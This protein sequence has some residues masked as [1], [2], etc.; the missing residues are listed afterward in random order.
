MENERE[1]LSCLF[2]MNR[3]EEISILIHK[4]KP[5]TWPFHIEQFK[6]VIEQEEL[7]LILFFLKRRECRRL[8]DDQYIQKKIVQKYLR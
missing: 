2:R 7:E 5:D 8:L 1:L 6:I 3:F 4:Y